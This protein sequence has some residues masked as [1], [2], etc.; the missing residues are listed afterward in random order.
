MEK[1]LKFSIPTAERYI[2]IYKNRDD[3]KIVRL[4]NLWKAEQ[5]LI[6]HKP[7]PK[8]ERGKK[9]PNIGG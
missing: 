7:K 6:E 8:T 4:T 2:K 9:W 3:P 5:S 1:N